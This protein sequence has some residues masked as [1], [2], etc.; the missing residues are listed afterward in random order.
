MVVD[1]AKEVMSRSVGIWSVLLFSVIF[2]VGTVDRQRW[3][4]V[5]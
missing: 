3:H 1:Q 4:S 5:P 2:F